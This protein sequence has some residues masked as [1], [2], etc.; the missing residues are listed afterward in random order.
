MQGGGGNVENAPIFLGEVATVRF[1]N[2]RPDNI[3]R[4]N[5]ERC[6]SLSVYKG[7]AVQHGQGG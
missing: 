3:V 1:E 7:D 5:G 6:I 4:L 2:A